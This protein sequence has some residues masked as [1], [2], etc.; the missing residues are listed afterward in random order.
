M[1]HLRID[2]KLIKLIIFVLTFLVLGVVIFRGG[3]RILH[4]SQASINWP[5]VQG[6][7]IRSE[8]RGDRD[9]NHEDSL[10]WADIQVRYVVHGQSYESNQERF[11]EGTNMNIQTV[12]VLVNR[13]PVG[14]PATV[15]YNPDNPQEALLDPGVRGSSYTLL[16]ISMF[17][18]GV[19]P[20]IARAIYRDHIA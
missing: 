20:I 7:V 16:L 19:I 5:T 1:K 14:Q 15:Y 6:E 10:P 3:L 18:F 2:I 9:R 4:R 17:V 12:R 11:E 8:V 13:Y